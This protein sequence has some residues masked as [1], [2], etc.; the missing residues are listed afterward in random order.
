MWRAWSSQ[1]SDPPAVREVG[2]MVR[3]GERSTRALFR[4]LADTLRWQSVRVAAMVRLA[5]NNCFAWTLW[6]EAPILYCTCIRFHLL[7][8]INSL[9]HFLIIMHNWHKWY[10]KIW[11]SLVA[12][13]IKFICNRYFIRNRCWCIRG[14]W[15]CVRVCFDMCPTHDAV[16]W[17][18]RLVHV[19]LSV[20]I[21][22]CDPKAESHIAPR[23]FDNGVAV[24]EFSRCASLIYRWCLKNESLDQSMFACQGRNPKYWWITYWDP[25]THFYVYRKLSSQ[26]DHWMLINSMWHVYVYI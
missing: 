25:W 20:S 15:T 26:P 7:R 2:T 4:T 12:T 23:T 13:L 19:P 1:C 14:H 11:C 5:S 3:K 6:A 24:I 8:F 22:I 17:P 9:F 18:S 10:C 21:G 16:V